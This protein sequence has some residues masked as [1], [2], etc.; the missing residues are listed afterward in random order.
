MVSVSQIHTNSKQI[1]QCSVGTKSIF[2]SDSM[3][4]KYDW[5]LSVLLMDAI[6]PQYSAQ[7]K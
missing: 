1:L 3:R 4:T 7:R 6:P 5:F 2:K